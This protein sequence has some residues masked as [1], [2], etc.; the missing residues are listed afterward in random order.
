M[1]WKRWRRFLLWKVFDVQRFIWEGMWFILM[2]VTVSVGQCSAKWLFYFTIVPERAS[3]LCVSCRMTKLLIFCFLQFARSF[4]MSCERLIA[5]IG[6]WLIRDSPFWGCFPKPCF[7][8]IEIKWV[9][10]NEMILSVDDLC[11][12]KIKLF[13]LKLSKNQIYGRSKWDVLNGNAWAYLKMKMNK[14]RR[15]KKIATLSMVRSITK[16]CRRRLGIKR[17]NFRIRK[18]LKVRKTDNPELVLP[19]SPLMNAWHNSTALWK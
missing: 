14:M 4:E 1:K 8:P 19:P 10:F 18:S 2:S 7:F 6:R 16:S 11:E 12:P 5:K 17:T 3:E 13:N 9:I 15:E